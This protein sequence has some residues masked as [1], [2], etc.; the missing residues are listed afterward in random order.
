[1]Y[2]VA[3]CGISLIFSFNPLNLPQK[4]MTPTLEAVVALTG[5]E[6]YG[7]LAFVPDMELTA[8]QEAIVSTLKARL[9]KVQIT[10]SRICGVEERGPSTSKS[11]E[12]NFGGW[13][14]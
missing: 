5:L 3:A 13:I 1:M 2:L 7:N 9:A 14:R 10:L 12:T 6:L 8:E 4:E 11:P